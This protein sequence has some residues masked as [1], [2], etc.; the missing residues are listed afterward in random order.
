MSDTPTLVRFKP[1]WEADGVGNDGLPLYRSNIL[2]VLSRPPFLMVER[3]AEEEDIAN[4]PMQFELFKKENAGRLKSYSEGY[5]LAMWPAVNEAE[6]RMLADRD[7]T[8]V[9]QLA[10]LAKKKGS[11]FEGM[12]AEI[13]TLAARAVKL[14]ELQKGAPK[15]EQIVAD[16]DG[17]IAALNEQVTD[18]RTANNNLQAR[19]SQLM[20][21]KNIVG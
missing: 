9:E 6:F 1:G 11:A 4:Y 21:M 20:S 5:P 2:I 3:V 7:I 10:Q 16:K 19:V 8:T 14:L 13:A 17:Q 15:F 18:L 12:P